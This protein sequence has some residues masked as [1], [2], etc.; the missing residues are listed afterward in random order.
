MVLWL[1]RRLLDL[2]APQLTGWLER[3]ARRRGDGQRPGSRA[4][5]RKRPRR[6]W[7]PSR[8]SRPRPPPVRG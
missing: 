5:P 7:P 8:R 2:L 3:Q 6:R 1:T 4:S